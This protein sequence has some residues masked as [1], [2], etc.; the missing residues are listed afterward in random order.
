[1]PDKRVGS[2]GVDFAHHVKQPTLFVDQSYRDAV[3][4]RFRFDF[5]GVPAM[6]CEGDA[7]LSFL[8]FVMCHQPLDLSL[9]LFGR[10]PGDLHSPVR[11]QFDRAVLLYGLVTG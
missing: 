10:H 1:M 5:I 4:D 9:D 8:C 2:G 6:G 7:S 3:V 11:P